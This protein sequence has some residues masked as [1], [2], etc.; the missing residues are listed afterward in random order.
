[1]HDNGDGTFAAYYM[2]GRP[3]K[4]KLNIRINDEHEIDGS[5]FD[6]EVLPSKTVPAA[7]TAEGEHLVTLYPDRPCGF[8]V[9]ARDGLGNK[10]HRGGDPFEVSIVGGA[11]LESIDDNGDGTYAVCFEAQDPSRSQ[12]FASNTLLINVTLY[13]K[14]ISG[15]PYRPII[16][17]APED[18]RSGGLNG[19]FRGDDEIEP[20]HTNAEVP[21][22]RKQSFRSS[23]G[24]GWGA[25]EAFGQG[26]GQGQPWVFSGS[27][28]SATAAVV[29]ASSSSS[30]EGRGEGRDG[31][32]AGA[33]AGEDAASAGRSHTSQER[34]AL[35]AARNREKLLMK[36]A[37]EAR[38]AGQLPAMGEAPLPN[39]IP[40]PNSNPDPPAQVTS[41]QALRSGSISGYSQSASSQAT[42]EKLST[43]DKSAIRSDLMRGL[44]GQLSA[45]ATDEERAYWSLAGAASSSSDVVAILMGKL[46]WLKQ[47][48]DLMADVVAASAVAGGA[49]EG[50]AAVNA[51]VRVLQL[52]SARRLLQE[53]VIVPSKLSERDVSVLFSLMATAQVCQNNQT[54]N[55]SPIPNRN[56]YPYPNNNPNPNPNPTPTTNLTATAQTNARHPAAA[57]LS[58][59]ALSF[60][61]Y[62]RFLVAAALMAVNKSPALSAEY[63]SAEVRVGKP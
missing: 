28:S 33:G 13:G 1:M 52:P 12:Y 6:I 9:V 40:N 38:A 15:S 43:A 50:A 63:S 31:A 19:L 8:T 18:D 58:G 51:G 24:S 57:L 26:Q 62:L 32:R 47:G 4:Y 41:L 37:A 49:A 20:E 27:S 2:L 34:L 11:H 22:A 10:K 17:E 21:S 39:P 25:L 48:F 30:R 29:G 36:R 14:H 60:P 53:Y 54:T 61:F 55:P 56:P 16:L 44:V 3:G 7:S 46:T 23:G 59:A 5:P 45:A 42:E 35:G